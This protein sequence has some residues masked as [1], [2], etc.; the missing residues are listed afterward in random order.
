MGGSSLR[1]E[2][3]GYHGE[4]VNGLPF[5]AVLATYGRH[6]TVM[7][8]GLLL[9]QSQSLSHSSATRCR[10]DTQ[11]QTMQGVTFPS[12]RVNMLTTAPTPSAH[13]VTLWVLV[14]SSC[15]QYSCASVPWI[16]DLAAA[17]MGGAFN[18]L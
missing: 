12:R 10:P 5:V 2:T 18:P 6:S 8:V 4:P 14:G 17:D 1:G 11:M 3:C 7:I 15:C 13:S 16:W 9:S